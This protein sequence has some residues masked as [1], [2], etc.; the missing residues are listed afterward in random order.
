MQMKR[1]IKRRHKI[2][3][4]IGSN[5]DAEKN[6]SSIRH[7]LTEHFHE[8]QFTSVLVNPFVGFDAPDFHNQ[9]ALAYTDMEEEETVRLLKQME[10]QL[11]RKPS[12]KHLHRIPAD[13]DLLLFDN[14]R[15]HEKDWQRPYVIALMREFD[16]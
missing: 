12:D 2:L 5:D 14:E 13:I 10:Q 1:N 8:V 3:L 16:E 6:I 7:L 15:R 9:L 4:A 11:G